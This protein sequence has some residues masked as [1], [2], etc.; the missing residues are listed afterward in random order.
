MTPQIKL[1]TGSTAA[2]AVVA[3][4]AAS[5]PA[6]STPTDLRTPDARE[7]AS[8]RS[9]HQPVDPKS[10]MDH[11][12]IEAALAQE[13][14]YESHKPVDAG[15]GPDLRTI[16]SRDAAKAPGGA[17]TRVATP[18]TPDPAGAGGFELDDAAIGAGSALGL[19]LVLA[20]G[21]A[22]LTRRHRPATS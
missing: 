16:D 6:Q 14:Y 5:A 2:L 21:A 11:R 22:A 20:G 10:R 13:R 8:Q 12:A 3:A 7:A 9:S 19:V 1:R 15:S 4:L 17:V 18:M